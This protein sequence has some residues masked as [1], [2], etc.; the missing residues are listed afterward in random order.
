M[1]P[2][3]RIWLFGNFPGVLVRAKYFRMSDEYEILIK[4][5]PF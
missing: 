2:K 5:F 1:F 4:I 3:A